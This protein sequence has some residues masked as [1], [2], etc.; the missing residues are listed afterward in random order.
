LLTGGRIKRKKERKK[1][2]KKFTVTTRP[3]KVVLWN[4]P[5][6]LVSQSNHGWSTQ[7]CR[8][9]FLF[10]VVVVVVVSCCVMLFLLF[11]FFIFFLSLKSLSQN[12]LH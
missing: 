12:H 5:P 10:F 11:L 1:E 9:V 7:A 4:A 2:R 3:I 8:T 6:P